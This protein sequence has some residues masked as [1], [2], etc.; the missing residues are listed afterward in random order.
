MR[1]ASSQT[2]GFGEHRR[3]LCG[4]EVRA[5]ELHARQQRAG[6]RQAR[7][8]FDL[9]TAADHAAGAAAE[10]EGAL[11]LAQQQVRDCVEARRMV[12]ADED[13]Q[14]IGFLAAEAG[15]DCAGGT[16]HGRA[17]VAIG[18]DCGRPAHASA[19]VARAPILRGCPVRVCA[20]VNVGSW[21]TAAW[22][23]LQPDHSCCRVCDP[24]AHLLVLQPLLHV[25]LRLRGE[26]GRAV[27]TEAQHDRCVHRVRDRELAEQPRAAAGV[28]RPA[29][30]PDRLDA[31]D[32][33]PT[34]AAAAARAGLLPIACIGQV[35]RSAVKPEC[36][37]ALTE[38]AC[39]R[40]SGS[41]GQA[42]PPSFSFRYSTIASESQ[43]CTSPSISTGTRRAE[44]Y[45][46][47]LLVELRRVQR[48]LDLA[49]RQR[50]SA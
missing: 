43:M 35:S 17:Q 1:S 27:V 22:L 18:I 11:E 7:P 26:T 4:I 46:H 14:Q 16:F 37:S 31:R 12:G 5:L 33:A 30:V 41:A 10:Q 42:R 50:R 25:R 23:G 49:K 13:D 6:Q 32:V 29:V 19:I 24:F 28:L 8:I 36:I 39:A 40:S 9:A 44:V 47:D 3:H 34:L 21:R 38:R 2:R 15:E 48:Q 45:A 20:A